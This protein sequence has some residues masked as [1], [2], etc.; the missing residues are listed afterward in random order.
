MAVDTLA[1]VYEAYKELGITVYY[2]SCKVAMRQMLDRCQFYKRVPKDCIF[3]SVHD[4]VQEA[5]QVGHEGAEDTLNLKYVKTNILR[6]P[7]AA[8][9]FCH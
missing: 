9:C 2:A 4:A 5:L 6:L 7:F 1:F 8:L 3:I